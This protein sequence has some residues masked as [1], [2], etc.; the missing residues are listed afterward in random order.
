MKIG[1]FA[2]LSVPLCSTSPVHMHLCLW[3]SMSTVTGAMWQELPGAC[4]IIPGCCLHMP[5]Q[6]HT[7][8]RTTT[9]PFVS[10]ILNGIR[11]TSSG[12]QPQQQRVCNMHSL[13]W[14]FELKSLNAGVHSTRQGAA[15]KGMV[16]AAHAA[17]GIFGRTKIQNIALHF[18]HSIWVSS[19]RYTCFALPN[20]LH[21]LVMGMWVRLSR[22]SACLVAGADRNTCILQMTMLGHRARRV[23]G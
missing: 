9:A 23:I 22:H 2:T 19:T 10:S 12:K 5:H 20:I 4:Y 16:W 7:Q 13:P 1:S 21:A 17:T 3:C 11:A 18:C 8:T 6:T 15:L 14:R